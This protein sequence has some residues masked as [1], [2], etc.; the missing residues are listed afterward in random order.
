M[1]SRWAK[2]E[3]GRINRVGAIGLPAKLQRAGFARQMDQV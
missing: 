3:L 2:V 1:R